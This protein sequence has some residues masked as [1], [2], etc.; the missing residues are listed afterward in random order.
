MKKI[1]L[2]TVLLIQCNY[3]IAQVKDISFT[4][5]PFA[6]YNWWDNK[7]GLENGTLVGGKLGFGFGE[8]IELRAVYAQSI[9]LKTNF[10][11][12]FYSNT[13]VEDLKNANIVYVGPHLNTNKITTLFNDFN[14][15]FKIIGHQLILSNHPKLSDKTYTTFFGEEDRDFSVISKF[16]GPNNNVCFIFMSNHDIGVKAAIENFTNKDFLKKF[17]AEQMAG[18]E[19]FTAIYETYGN[20][21]TNLGFKRMIVVPF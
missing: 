15:Y 14:P 10:D 19:N 21:R 11:L 8:Y 17:N 20:D 16:K 6:E 2:T 18:K 13:S 3:F 4:I 5:S 7:S 1:L 12:R 9:D